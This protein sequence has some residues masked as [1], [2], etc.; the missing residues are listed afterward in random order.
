MNNT[1]HK[2]LL[3]IKILIACKYQYKH[4]ATRTPTLNMTDILVFNTIN[5]KTYFIHF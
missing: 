4:A 5:Y 1:Y 3:M 2:K